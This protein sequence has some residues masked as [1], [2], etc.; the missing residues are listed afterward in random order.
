M[1]VII[2][3]EVIVPPAE[4]LRDL[5]LIRHNVFIKLVGRRVQV[6]EA[7]DPTGFEEVGEALAVLDER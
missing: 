7:V 6:T 3:E 2:Y 5:L 4:F 1:P